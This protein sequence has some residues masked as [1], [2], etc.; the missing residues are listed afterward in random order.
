M[1]NSN[2]PSQNHRRRIQRR[3]MSLLF[4][5]SLILFITLLGTSFIVVATQFSQSAKIR[6]R[7]QARGDSPRQVVQRAFY[8]LVRGPE[9]G[10]AQSALY[11]GHSILADMYGYGIGGVVEQ[12]VAVNAPSNNMVPGT[13]EFTLTPNSLVDL[14]P[15]A[16]STTLQLSDIP[17]AYNGLVLTFARGLYSGTSVRIIGYSGNLPGANTT[18]P[19]TFTA[20]QEKSRNEDPI[21]SRTGGSFAVGNIIG[22]S[23]VLNGRAYHGY[24]A[25]G[26]ASGGL[27]TNANEPNRSEKQSSDPANP[28]LS[29]EPYT[30]S[31]VNEN[32]D[33]SNDWQTMFLASPL[34]PDGQL[35]NPSFERP[36]LYTAAQ[37][38]L[39]NFRAF[40]EPSN[41]PGNLNLQVDNNG[42]GV[43]DS[44][45][46]DPGYPIQTDIDGRRYKNLVSY[47]VVDMDGRFNVNAH[48][49][50]YQSDL[51]GDGIYNNRATSTA[52]GEQYLG[53][54][55]P[56]DWNLPFGQ[57]WGPPEISLAPALAAAGDIQQNAYYVNLLTSRY[58]EDLYP[59]NA[60]LR[61][62][63]NRYEQ[64]GFPA[65][66]SIVNS[67]EV[68]PNLWTGGLFG[69][70]LDLSGRYTDGVPQFFA[71]NS[72]VPVSLNASIEG[73]TLI[74][75]RET[76]QSP[77]EFSL[78]ENSRFATVPADVSDDRPY[79][80]KEMEKWLRLYDRDSGM[81]PNRL[82]E[83]LSNFDNLNP[84]I[85]GHS[86]FETPAIPGFEPDSTL[87]QE[88][89][90]GSPVPIVQRV[91]HL[92]VNNGYDPA[93]A[94]NMVAELLSP[95][96]RM[97]LPFD[98][99]RPFGDGKDNNNNGIYDEFTEVGNGAESL[100][101]VTGDL[102]AM[103]PDGDGNPATNGQ[104][105][106][107][108][109]A[110]E[111]YVLLLLATDDTAPIAPN[112]NPSS[113]GLTDDA[114]RRRVA[115]AQ[116]AVNVADFRDADSINTPFEFDFNPFNENGWAADGDLSTDDG[117]DTFVVW[118]LE[119]P[120]L[121]LT[122]CT[123]FHDRRTE[124]TSTG[125]TVEDGD[126][127]FDSKLVPNAS[128]FFEL[129]RP[130]SQNEFDQIHPF[131]LGGNAVG[132]I[133]LAQDS[134]GN[135][136]PVWRMVVS[137]ETNFSTP[138]KDVSNDQPGLDA[139][140]AAEQFRRIYF[141]RPND[142]VEPSGGR[143]KAYWP[144]TDA[145][146]VAEE[147]DG[148]SLVGPGGY[149]VVGSA[150]TKSL[151]AY[152]SWAGR[153]DDPNWQTLL[154]ETRGVSLDPVNR[155]VI[156]RTGPGNAVSEI[157]EN[158][159]AI[160]IDTTG[161]V[162][163]T[164][165]VRRSLGVS[166]P[167]DGYYTYGEFTGTSAP[168]APT[169]VVAV[170][171]G[172][173]FDSTKDV[174]VDHP[175]ARS[176]GVE[177]F[178]MT[179][180]QTLN[181]RSVFLQRLA[182]PTLPFDE[183]TNPYLTIDRQLIDLVA[184]NGAAD[185][186]DEPGIGT[187]IEAFA[188]NERGRASNTERVSSPLFSDPLD[189]RQLWPIE[190][191]GEDLIAQAPDPADDHF[192]KIELY[193]SLGLVNNA[194]NQPEFDP[195]APVAFGGLTWHNRPYASHMELLDVPFTNSHQ[196]LASPQTI[197][198][199][200]GYTLNRL[201]SGGDPFAEPVY[202]GQFGHLF[203][204]FSPGVSPAEPADLVRI[205]D[206]VRT[207]SMFPGTKI[208]LNSGTPPGDLAIAP[209]NTLSRYREP[210][211]INVNTIASEEV[212]GGL[213]GPYYSNLNVDGFNT[214]GTPASFQLSKVGNVAESARILPFRNATNALVA[215]AG[216]AP[217][218]AANATLLREDGT[219]PLLS[220]D[221]NFP[222]ADSGSDSASHNDAFRRMGSTTTNRSSVFAIWV[223]VGK[224]EV[225]ENGDLLTVSG[226][227][228]ELGADEGKNKRSRGF[229]LIDRSIPVGFQPGAD[230]NVEK[231]ILAE[232]I[233]D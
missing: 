196:L 39:R 198:A 205:F 36:A 228:V 212:A 190:G 84:H 71:A 55:N 109:F 54:V 180:G 13:F 95:E 61:Q 188:T 130:W 51:D 141:T 158:V 52:G 168:S 134:T 33:S 73:T 189:R 42:D 48:G 49:T 127:H 118:G 50:L 113:G 227:G 176:D 101:S 204:F 23:V 174:P 10:N 179:N 222:W 151:G 125:E 124:D 24:G 213:L 167:I 89:G 27:G 230:L 72:N 181:F 143:Q 177:A 223:T 146:G 202:G 122:E 218:S 117:A 79:T 145:G 159:V 199:P 203:N 102:V 40:G 206:F 119:R 147:L 231:I 115:L 1:R 99:N 22:A 215:P 64:F 156:V 173:E 172:Y 6:T 20:Y 81:L 87:P 148:N 139:I 207:P 185:D 123:A 233:M 98:L 129:Y 160:P 85:I 26:Y 121:L 69:T 164:E 105:A 136:D 93:T 2:S 170:G 208:H 90:L 157:R 150:G 187:A 103:D 65:A 12:A 59:G 186:A 60:N 96:L 128:V 5:V 224:F 216:E 29:S 32:W 44:I 178:I 175:D 126:E 8:D 165:D 15:D 229:F 107:Y 82:V 35:M 226:E 211:K 169:G 68:F 112:T 86:S 232:T 209:F 19:F 3:G 38:P 110:K 7:L 100:Q 43:L 56:L 195:I 25:G 74:P 11:G 111:L 83:N 221:S 70:S 225:D 108:R 4:V 184:F 46:I 194:Y 219:D 116:W 88:A 120:E 191:A 153:R 161:S 9:P 34:G 197:G 67:G 91:H 53:G 163:G 210:G 57:Y 47:L 149:A 30:A 41:S 144:G 76:G 80:A 155:E 162:T 75:T 133:D 14:R 182:D 77:Y 138:W 21:V 45:W 31:G 137:T 183:D 192:L 217:P 16:T 114:T 62:A 140:D 200:V 63:W 142:V 94:G 17:G 135:G 131:E 171:D 214:D 106:R 28:A 58:G 92:L 154:G 201:S 166:D 132:G 66:P 37:S 220:V 97:G 193:E 104:W 152:N 18:L 78:M